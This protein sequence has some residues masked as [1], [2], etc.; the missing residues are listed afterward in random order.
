M[1]RE[2]LVFS[3][4][5]LLGLILSFSSTYAQ[6]P[7]EP[8]TVSF[9][10][11]YN[12]VYF[13]LPSGP[14]LAFVHIFFENDDSVAGISA[15]FIFSGPVVYDSTTFRDSRVNYMLYKNV[16]E[17]LIGSNKVLLSAIPVTEHIIGP[18]RGY[19]ATL[20]FRV[21]GDTGHVVVDTAFFPPSNHL[22]FV[23]SEPEGYTPVFIKGVLPVVAYKPGD[24]N[25]DMNVNVN[26][27]IF[28]INYLFKNG[29]DPYPFVSVD[30]NASCDIN[31]VDVIYL[32]NYLFKGGPAL[33]PG[34]D[35]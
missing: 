17:T 30:V 10:T 33:K 22:T 8:D 15:P 21:I 5:L 13:P 26:D 20:C 32:I 12:E 29:P 4:I 34:C 27:V 16:N 1:K 24:A 18:G 31:V 7:K 9:I 2:K 14:G 35:W 25:H 28:L 11:R 23:T 6:D 19:L 3:L